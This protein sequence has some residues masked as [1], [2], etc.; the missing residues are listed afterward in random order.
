[1]TPCQRG[2]C[3]L[4]AGSS[5]KSPPDRSKPMELRRRP[6]NKTPEPI[7]REGPLRTISTD[8]KDDWTT[9]TGLRISGGYD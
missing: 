8:R 3:I 5:A 4:Q 2:L 7:G 1:M 6:R 9:Q